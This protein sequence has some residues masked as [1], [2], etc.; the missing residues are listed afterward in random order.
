MTA[1]D[2]GPLRGRLACP[3][4]CGRV[5]V[6]VTLAALAVL[7][8]LMALNMRIGDIP[9]SVAE[10]V[11]AHVDGATAPTTSSSWSSACPAR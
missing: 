10:V 3:G 6:A 11:R 8:L 1:T 4:G 2:L 7:G 5:G 9:M